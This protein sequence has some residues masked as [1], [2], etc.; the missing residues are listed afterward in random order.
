[1][2][3]AVSLL[4]SIRSIA[5]GQVCGSECGLVAGN[6]GEMVGS[7]PVPLPGL[8]L[9]F[10]EKHWTRYEIRTDVSG[11]YEIKVPYGTYW[12][13]VLKDGTCAVRRSD[14][15]IS[16]GERLHFDFEL[17]ACPSDANEDE[18]SPSYR[19]EAIPGDRRSGRPEIRI[20]FG[21]RS[22]NGAVDTYKSFLPQHSDLPFRVTVTAD[23]YTIRAQKVTFYR[24]TMSV[25]AEGDVE[26]SDGN[27]KERAKVARLI[28]Q[29]GLPK[30]EFGNAARLS[31]SN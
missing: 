11:K 18:S 2:L 10:V 6:V 16:P 17:V 23:K 27:K 19:E 25:V 14:F 7:S 29:D 21:E 9:V 30:I 8:R 5:E 31:Q 15:H 13:E 20:A 28:Y 12:V 4:T 3:L 22:S 1:M 26:I 24:G